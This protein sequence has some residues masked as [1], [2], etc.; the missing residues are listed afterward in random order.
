MLAKDIF[1]WHI[2]ESNRFTADIVEPL[3][4]GA[5]LQLVGVV[6]GAMKGNGFISAITENPDD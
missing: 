6:V 2:K 1:V 4:S 3:E 5:V